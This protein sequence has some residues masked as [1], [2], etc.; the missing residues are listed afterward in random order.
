MLSLLEH[1]MIQSK[2]APKLPWD[3]RMLKRSI[4]DSGSAPPIAEATIF[5]ENRNIALIPHFS[6]NA[7]PVNLIPHRHEFFEMSYVV[8]GSTEILLDHFRIKVKKGDF[9]IMNTNSMHT[10]DNSKPVTILNILVKQN[11]L[12]A[13]YMKYILSNDIFCTFFLKNAQNVSVPSF[14]YW[15]QVGSETME[16]ILSLMLEEY[17]QN[18]TMSDEIVKMQLG[19]LLAMISRIQPIY[20]VPVEK[21]ILIHVMQ[22]IHKHLDSANLSELAQ[23]MHYNTSYLSKRIKEETGKTFSE[24]YQES[25]MQFAAE[26]LQKTQMTLEAISARAGYYDISHFCRHFKKRYGFTPNDY[27]GK[28]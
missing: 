6:E 20:G 27:R 21:G 13:D 12:K 7:P 16:Q 4:A 23:A 28:K 26:L 18:Q 19:T 14:L 24:L 17:S 15:K 9:T 22:Y 11:C 1:M 25:R 8:D 3:D 5:E 10:I 2:E